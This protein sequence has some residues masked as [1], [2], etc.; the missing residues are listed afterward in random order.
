MND[1]EAGAPNGKE[2]TGLEGRL[3]GLD[4]LRA[5]AILWVM[6]FHLNGHFPEALQAPSHYGWMGV[7]LF[8]VLSGFLIAS[9]LF[10]PILSGSRLAVREFYA[11]RA[12]RILP[13]F[14]VVLLL[15]V[16]VPGWREAPGLQPAWQFATFTENLLI[17]YGRNQA[18]SH[19]WSLC[20]EE[21][22]YLVLPLLTMLMMRRP[23]AW[24]VYALLAFVS[25]A[26]VGMR[27]YVLVHVLRP[28]G[29]DN[30]RFGTTF[31]ET[32]YYPTYVRLDGLLAGVALASLRAFR[33]RWWS[34][35]MRRG[36]TLAFAGV[37]LVA[38]VGWSAPA[39]YR[40]VTGLAVFADL[41][42]YPLLGLGFALLTASA[43]SQNGLLARWRVPGAKLIALLAFSLYL[44]HKEAVHLLL[45]LF[46]GLPDNTYRVQ[47]LYFAVC[48]AVAGTL[49]L[50]VERP[51][52]RLRE[53]RRNGFPKGAT[54]LQARIDPAL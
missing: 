34:V 54:E 18:F 42:C 31:I 35:L 23:A 47:P 37:G 22:F 4:T 46:P 7:D 32:M 36:H 16:F 41:F 52:L 9:Q 12:Y 40:A 14:F 2:K 50:G 45:K 13:A 25:L 43:L 51:F 26:G 1:A 10:R 21:H 39:R 28:L 15:Y 49:Y 27:A 29:P 24:K 19:A 30:D 53:R 5:F 11:R 6:P 8:F 33:A 17:D 20:V 48:L 44:T 38:F 3:H